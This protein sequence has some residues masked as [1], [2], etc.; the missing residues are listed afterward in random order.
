MLVFGHPR[1]ARVWACLLG[2]AVAQVSMGAMGSL[3][4]ALGQRSRTETSSAIIL[5]LLIERTV[6]QSGLA[7]AL[8][9]E[10]RTVMRV[11]RELSVSGVPLDREEDPPHV[12][13]SVPQGWVPGGVTFEGPLAGELLE[14]LSLVPRN[15]KR[16]K[17]MERIVA[18]IS[19]NSRLLEVSDG[20]GLSEKDVGVLTQIQKSAAE[21]EALEIRYFSASSRALS[22]RVVSVQRVE[23]GDTPRFVAFCH[24]REAPRW[25]RLDGVEAV[26]SGVHQPY[27]EMDG[28]ALKSFLDH[29][30]SGY[31]DG[32]PPVLCEFFVQDSDWAWV[33]RN[34]PGRFEHR[35]VDGGY[36]CTGHN[37]ALP[38]VA[39]FVV[40]L[41]DA[42]R[43]LS[44]GLAERVQ[45]LAKGALRALKEDGAA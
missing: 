42:A 24:N 43:P 29:S 41:G 7:K 45:K 3:G 10:S 27:V 19:G 32:L 35:R 17:L 6:S 21:R 28:A 2:I 44:P 1:I 26:A 38:V 36:I 4:V 20:P 8:Q 18:A 40:G 31:N 5:K 12:Y 9:L 13:W 33:G 14:Q 34:L 23:V 22:S 37:A 11:L 39:S 25:F 15:D 30:G 16:D